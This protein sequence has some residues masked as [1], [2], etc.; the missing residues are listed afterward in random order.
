[1]QLARS[2]ALVL[3]PL[4]LFA[5]LVALMA[6]NLGKPQQATIRSHMVGKPVPPF[7]LEGVAGAQGFGAADLAMGRPILVNVFASWCLPCAVE[8]P[9]LKTL[10][11]S[12]VPLYGIAVRDQPDDVAA[13][14]KR[15]GNPFQRIGADPGGRMML[16]FGA[17][18]VPET[19]VVDGKGIIRH[20]H[21]GEIRPEHVPQLLAAVERAK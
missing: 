14:L 9:Q 21:L 19:Y 1:M 17:S 16:A 6:T 7:Q 18:G 4:L 15:H 2:R 3:L 12:G 11:A 10:Q 13:F 20:Q 5:G 8:A